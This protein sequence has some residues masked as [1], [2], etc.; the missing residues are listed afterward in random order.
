MSA[1]G[2]KLA[3][4][5][6][7]EKERPTAEGA[8]DPGD[9]WPAPQ[10]RLPRRP[11]AA[12]RRVSPALPLAPTSRYAATVPPPLAPPGP[13]AFLLGAATAA[14]AI[15]ALRTRRPTAPAPPPPSVPDRVAAAR[16]RL[17]GAPA[18]E[19]L[20]ALADPGTSEGAS[21]LLAA[22]L[23][24]PAVPFTT[25]QLAR[26]ASLHG[27]SRSVPGSSHPDPEVGALENGATR[28]MT[29]SLPL[30]R[31]RDA[32]RGRLGAAGLDATAPLR[33]D[34]ANLAC[35]GVLEGLEL[36]PRWI[37]PFG[38]RHLVS[39][40]P[41][42]GVELR[43]LADPGGV[44]RLHYLDLAT[45]DLLVRRLPDGRMGLFRPGEP[46]PFE[47]L[48]ARG[49]GQGLAV[50]GGRVAILEGGPNNA[51]L[52][53]HDLSS[54]P[55][56]WRSR[57]FGWDSRSGDFPIATLSPGGGRIALEIDYGTRLEIYDVA[58]GRTLLSLDRPQYSPRLVGFASDRLV[59]L[60]ADG[61]LRAHDL[62]AGGIAWSRDG[63][64]SIVAVLPGNGELLRSA[65]GGL[66]RLSPDG[67]PA[68]SFPAPPGKI[69][70]LVPD[71][72]SGRFAVVATT[73]WDAD[74]NLWSQRVTIHDRDGREIARVDP[75]F[76]VAF[77]APSLAGD[78][79]TGGLFGPVWLWRYEA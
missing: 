51:R 45:P 70:A 77:L 73:G 44:E 75:A 3:A 41:G 27:I 76:S 7:A 71:P 58:S 52:A 11:L 63:A 8:E 68:A 22:A 16:A 60:E 38:Q 48:E 33:P 4:P 65:P 12:P 79:A 18:E 67:R 35:T 59:L 61:A 36:E 5:A 23:G 24:D 46:A 47:R 66:E 62:D 43:D 54:P 9:V 31:L 21:Q 34:A 25:E 69:E 39:R 15:F 2:T 20:G 10:R 57:G 53:V 50:A 42:L 37:V 1:G 28:G 29:G 13:L 78:L 56:A 19:L 64:P 14:A 26:I 40:E 74:A 72:R 30:A 17:A 55:A 49:G 32:A 6:G